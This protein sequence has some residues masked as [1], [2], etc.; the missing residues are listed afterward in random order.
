MASALHRYLKT[1]AKP[2]YGVIRP[3]Q[4][5]TI[6]RRKSSH[7]YQQIPMPMSKKQGPN[8]SILVRVSCYSTTGKP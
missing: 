1:S 3:A 5:V 6:L 2:I 8:A 7:H 4:P